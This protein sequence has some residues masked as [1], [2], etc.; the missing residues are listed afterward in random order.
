[1]LNVVVYSRLRYAAKIWFGYSW[2]HTRLYIYSQLRETWELRD[3]E[4]HTHIDRPIHRETE[5]QR[6]ITLVL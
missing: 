4:T 3:K 5:R 6:D 2:V 1:M